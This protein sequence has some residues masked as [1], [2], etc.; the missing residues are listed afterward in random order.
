MTL[1]EAIH[2]KVTYILSF[3]VISVSLLVIGISLLFLRPK[4]FIILILFAI[5]SAAVVGLFDKLLGLGLDHKPLPVIES[6]VNNVPCESAKLS[7]C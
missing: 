5:A 3:P 4:I 2:M 7:D 1:F 6:Q